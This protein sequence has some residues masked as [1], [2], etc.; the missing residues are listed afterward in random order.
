MK[1]KL[2]LPCLR[3]VIGNWVY[4]SSLMNAK[5]INEWILPAKDIRETKALDDILQRDLKDRRKK[6][7]N[8]LLKDDSRFFNSIIIGV[9]SGVPDWVEFDLS[10]AK[11]LIGNDEEQE[12]IKESV[13][14]LTFNGDEKMFAIDGQH[15]VSGIQIAYGEDIK[16][17]IGDRILNDD[18]FSIIFIAHIDDELGK[19]RTRK[20]FSDI[21]KKAVPVAE[22]DKI[23]IDEE[24][25]N[26]IVTRKLYANYAYFKQGSIISLTESAKLDNNDNSNF[27]NLLGI[28]NT[29]KVLRKLFKKKPKTFEWEIENVN[30]FYSIVTG[31]YDFS[32]RN[33]EEY[34][35]YFIAN[36]L[37]IEQARTQNKYL[38]FRPIGLKLLAGLYV[39]YYH[40]ENGLD[41]L[42]N[43]IN[44]IGFIFPHSPFN[45]I[46]WN[47]G[48]MEAKESNQRIALDLAI[49]LL[50]D[51]PQKDELNLLNRYRDIL[52]NTEVDL[53]NKVVNS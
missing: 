12:Y 25:L 33:I 29:N 45:N 2:I 52:R 27:T 22:G 9:F 53:P 23:K 44:K 39:H 35:K 31:F 50:G 6:I 26:A 49:Y 5:Q 34:K 43:N 48:K 37:S 42:K 21:N 18:Q 36:T 15:R 41:K 46:L 13:G 3:G 30:I 38:L 14:L 8:Y 20:L 7:A 51:L 24:D 17:P 1:Q 47:N 4:Y 32:I 28:N 40:L 16:K 11:D 19:K 10:K